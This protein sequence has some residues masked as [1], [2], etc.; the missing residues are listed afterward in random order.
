MRHSRQTRLAEVGGRGQLRLSQASARVSAGGF[1]GEVAAA[2][3]AGAGVGSLVV[4][5]GPAAAAAR[6][7]DPEVRVDLDPSLATGD[8]SPALFGLRHA[9]ARDLAAGAFA[10]LDRIR[11]I[12]EVPS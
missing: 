7:V 2:Y 10:A 12:L 3:L 1:A 8:V 9:T 4:A 5:D 6:A 11:V